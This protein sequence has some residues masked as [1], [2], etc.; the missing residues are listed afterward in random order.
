MGN[1]RAHEKRL[2]TYEGRA[3][4]TLANPFGE[5]LNRLLVFRLPFQ[6][7][8]VRVLF[9]GCRVEMIQFE[10]MITPPIG[11]TVGRAAQGKVA[12]R[13]SGFGAGAGDV[14]G[15]QEH[16][17]KG[18]RVGFARERLRCWMALGIRKNAIF[19]EDTVGQECRLIKVFALREIDIVEDAAGEGRLRK[20]GLMELRWADKFARVECGMR[21]RVGFEIILDKAA[22]REAAMLKIAEPAG[23][24]KLTVEQAGM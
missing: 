9:P 21:Q 14:I 5:R 4:P 19:T 17:C 24:I 3:A 11:Q 1:M 2:V 23:V 13:S 7:E 10:L 20:I 6:R 12:L 16:L 15:A 22:L 18:L 8:I